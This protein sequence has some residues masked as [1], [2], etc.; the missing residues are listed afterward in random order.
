VIAR[1]GSAVTAIPVNGVD[2]T[3][4]ANFG[5]G[6]QIAPG[7]FVVYDDNYH[8]A[9]VYALNAGTTYYFKVFEYDGTGSN[10]IYL[11]SSFAAVS[12]TTVTK[13]TV[14]SVA[15]ATTNITANSLRLNF[16]PGNGRAR[17]AIARSGS[18]VNVT[19]AD[20]TLYTYHANFGSG[21]DLGNGNF[22]VGYTTGETMGIQNLQANTTYHFAIYEL[23]G[24]NQPLYLTP[25]TTISATT[26]ATLPVKLVSWEATVANNKVNL[27][28]KTGSEIN[29]SHFVVE[30]SADGRDFSPVATTQAAG[31]STVGKAYS[32]V[33]HQPLYGKSYYRLK[34]VDKDAVWEYSAI[35]T[36]STAGSATIKI[37]Q[38]PVRNNCR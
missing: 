37:L 12:G 28:W 36:V 8:G 13:P 9:N 29:A 10:T 1:Q 4:N 25:A 33:D 11:T 19:P 32:I 20:F 23:N 6:Q 30:R 31:N 3:A 18:P 22:A 24:F 14:Q 35:R 15:G 21:Q 17:L 2:Y 34:M 5:Q 38:N 27:Q 16:T 26:T 7:E